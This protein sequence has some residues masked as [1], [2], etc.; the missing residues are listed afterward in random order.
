[1]SSHTD[2]L[3]VAGAYDGDAVAS[4]LAT[5]DLDT[6]V[7]DDLSTATT[8][9]DAEVDCVV[10]GA[11]D[12]HTVAAL[13]ARLGA[14]AP[15]V[16]LYD[17][18][19]D[20]TTALD[21]G[22]VA[23][24]PAGD[25]ST[26]QAAHLAATVDSVC[27]QRTDSDEGETTLVREA[28]DEIGD[29]VVLFDLDGKLLRWNRELVE[30][31][32]YADSEVAEMRPTD[33]FPDEAVETIENA[34]GRVVMQGRAVETAPLQTSD[35]DEIPHE[36]TGALVDDGDRQCICAI[37]RDIRDR[38]RRERELAEQADRLDTLNRVNGVIRDVTSAL[39]RTESR[40]EIEQTVCDRLAAADPYDFAWVGEYDADSDRV[41]PTA[42]AGDGVDYLQER[43]AA[44]DRE[45]ETVTAVT[46][47]RDRQV[48][49]A[50]DIAADPMTTTWREAALDRGYESAAAIPI[51]YGDTVY[52]CL[53]VYAPRPF[54]FEP[55]EREVLAELG[56]TVGHAI[57]A[58]ETR[59]ALVT[60]T[61]TE[62]QF[63]IVDPEAFIVE[64]ADETDARLELTGTVSREGGQLFERY[65]VRGDAVANIHDLAE[66]APS[67]IEILAER[68]D[69]CLVQ[70]PVEDV[71]LAETMADLGGTVRT[72]TVGD[73][74]AR[75]VVEVPR[76]AAVSEVLT[77][78]NEV[79]DVELLSQREI[80]RETTSTVSFKNAV[81][82]DLT[83]RQREVLL[84][85]YRAG[86]FDW[87]RENSGDELAD[88]LDVSPP[89]FHQHLRV[90]ERKLLDALFDAAT[91]TAVARS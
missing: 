83:A 81:D 60:N 75:I 30:A 34:I 19:S 65:T 47:V 28:L 17:R 85:S 57:S 44:G 37:G 53:C 45:S 10:C 62:L 64:V 38:Q 29:L 36:F 66:R 82:G 50:Q 89:T 55:L 35:G 80:D 24:F 3:V 59:K 67:H 7:V 77:R 27:R 46:A 84:T 49:F 74:D 9:L 6:T 69:E 78:T 86:F 79:I 48:R 8:V 32:G 39:L 4:C 22:A 21:A 87:P 16:F 25:R 2:V 63:G 88:L 11:L 58:A 54:A 23:T 91:T 76:D 26:D 33:F 40:E 51:V 61:V 41:E 52:G 18:E 13:V 56:E 90:A 68:E 20:A 70:V 15:V 71:S 73:G 12:R 1:M 5:R 42:W 31:T 43:P 14:K 72:V